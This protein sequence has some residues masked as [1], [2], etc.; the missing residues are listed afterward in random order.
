MKKRSESTKE[1][2]IELEAIEGKPDCGHVR[3]Q[4]VRFQ[5]IEKYDANFFIQIH[6]YHNSTCFFILS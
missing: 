5:N 6:T 3:I 2:S 4:H 1:E